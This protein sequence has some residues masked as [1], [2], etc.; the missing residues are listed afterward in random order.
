[1]DSLDH[2]IVVLQMW[3]SS[4]TTPSLHHT[5]V[6]KLENIRIACEFPDVFLEDLPGMPPDW[7]VEFTIELQPDTASISKQLY[8]MT[9]GPEKAIRGGRGG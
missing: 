1:L 2:G 7:D 3:S 6:Q 8:K 9:E 4:S 5:T